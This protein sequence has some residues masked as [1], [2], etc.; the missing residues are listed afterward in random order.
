M[1]RRTI[2]A[3]I[4]IIIWGASSTV[5]ASPPIKMENFTLY[6]ENDTFG[7][8]DKD[9]TNAIKLTW[10]SDDIDGNSSDYSANDL[11][12]IGK[13]WSREGDRRHLSFSLGQ[14]IYT[15][16]N[17]DTMVLV[18][19]ERPYAGYLYASFALHRRNRFVL[20]TLELTLGVVGPASQAEETQSLIHNIIDTDSPAGW[21]N[22]LGDE[23][24]VTLTWQRSWQ[25][26]ASDFDGWEW[27][28][29]PHFGFSLGNVVTF[30]NAGF[31]VRFGRKSFLDYNI[32]PVRPGGSVLVPM[33]EPEGRSN[34]HN[35]RDFGVIWFFRA[36]GRAV[37]HNVFLDGNTFEDSHS[38]DK[39]NFVVDLSAGVSFIYKSVR[40]TYA[41]IYRT[42]E[43]KEKDG[44]HTFGSIALS[45]MY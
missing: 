29:M 26:A 20:D 5:F 31:G 44:G 14:D 30:A 32:A 1:Y 19:D 13:F 33:A 23:L 6:F 9:Y 40:L 34:R 28:I 22:Q 15:P 7:G 17:T 45:F 8:T 18:E 41:Q 11:P 4:G 25:A 24:G 35:K 36:E 37:A 21:D 27:D 39:E 2:L 10:T 12:L 3:L 16:E 42:S 43:Y 38:V